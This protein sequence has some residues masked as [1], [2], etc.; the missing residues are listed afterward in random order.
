M[1]KY[2]N[3]YYDKEEDTLTLLFDNPADSICKPT[4]LD[5]KDV[6][7]RFHMDDNRLVSCTIF[8][9]SKKTDGGGP[10]CLPKRILPISR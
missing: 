8:D 2:L 4:E 3:I 9:F 7:C 5:E 10:L 1:D 6:M